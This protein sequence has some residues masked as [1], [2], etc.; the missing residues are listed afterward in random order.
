MIKHIVFF[1]L[2]DRSQENIEKTRRV[3][4]E[5]EGKIPVLRELEIGTDVLHLERSYDLVLVATFDSL[6]DLHTYDTHPVH[7]EVIAYI[8]QVKDSVI[9]VDYEC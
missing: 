3:L 7:Q 9:S 1:K 2:Q 8:K 4:A 5:M 6:Q